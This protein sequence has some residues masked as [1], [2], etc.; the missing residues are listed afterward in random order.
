M[1]NRDCE[2]HYVIVKCSK[3]VAKELNGSIEKMR[4]IMEKN[5]QYWKER[6]PFDHEFID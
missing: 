5:K 1:I 2:Y 6:C 4:K 3:T